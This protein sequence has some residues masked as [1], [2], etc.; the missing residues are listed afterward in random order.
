MFSAHNRTNIVILDACRDNPFKAAKTRNVGFGL[1][2]DRFKTLLGSCI[3]VI[4]TDPRRTVGAMCHIV[5]VGQPNA[6][7]VHNTAYGE[8][9]MH[10]M[11]DRLLAVGIPAQRCHAAVSA[12][13]A[14]PVP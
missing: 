2:G 3:S 10:A 11:F 9:A 8:V 4:L 14:A 6:A 13:T 1:A 5:H 7:N 12:G